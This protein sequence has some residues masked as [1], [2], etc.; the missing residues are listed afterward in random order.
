MT[1]HVRIQLVALFVFDF[2]LSMYFFSFFL[3]FIYFFLTLS[4]VD[5]CQCRVSSVERWILVRLTWLAS[6]CLRIDSGFQVICNWF[7]CFFVF[8]WF[9]KIGVDFCCCCEKNDVCC[10]KR[11]NDPP[12]SPLPSATPHLMKRV[13]KGRMTTQ[14]SWLKWIRAIMNSVNKV[15]V[16]QLQIKGGCSSSQCSS[17]WAAQFGCPFWWSWDGA[18]TR[19]WIQWNKLSN[20]SVINGGCA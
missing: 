9:E 8:S 4:A 19:P 14:S 15:L 18:V 11:N 2:L 16:S 12:P 7:F 1:F 17:V 3:L 10:G 5:R 13:I 20:P 6:D